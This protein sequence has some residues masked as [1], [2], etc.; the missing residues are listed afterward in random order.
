MPV[1]SFKYLPRSFR[2]GYEGFSYQHEEAAWA[3]LETPI[4]QATIALLSSAGIYLDGTQPSFDL[5][6]ERAQPTW[7]D[8]TYR[9]IPREVDQ[10]DVR[11][12]HLHIDGADIE[13]DINVALPLRAFAALEAEERIGMLAAEHYS[14]MGFQDRELADWRA[15]Q[16]PELVG[17][18]Q[19]S[20]VSALVLAPA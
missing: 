17:R 12:S 15:T 19:A 3:P 11:V 4:E 5:D 18:L 16:I 7:G 1:D 13:Q 6:R 14:F 8:P 10:H 20:G 2:A 9:V